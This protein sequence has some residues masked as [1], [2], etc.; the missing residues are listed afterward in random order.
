MNNY[1]N[2]EWLREK[3][4]ELGSLKAVAAL[5]NVDHTTILRKFKKFGIEHSHGLCKGYKTRGCGGYILVK[6]YKG[7]PHA[8]KSG[9]VLEHRYVMEQHLGRFLE[10]NE[11]VHHI[12]GDKTDNRL[13]NLLLVTNSE[14]VYFHHG[15]MNK[16]TKEVYN[17][18]VELRRGGNLVS[19]ICKLVGLS[20][21][22]ITKIL[23]NIPPVCGI[24]GK[25]C[26]SQTGLGMHIIRTHRQ[27][28]NHPKPKKNFFS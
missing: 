26:K 25:N 1:D 22:P 28:S 27:T 18:I 12:N 17:K 14:H 11:S 20:K 21:P 13:E 23:K 8:S 10:S 15:G 7:Y 5:C 2:P 24:C 6:A 4:K 19:E 16:K 3:Y 9:Y